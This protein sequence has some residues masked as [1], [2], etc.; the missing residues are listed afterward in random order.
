MGRSRST[1]SPLGRL[2]VGVSLVAL[3][4]LMAVLSAFVVFDRDAGGLLVVLVALGTFTA[5]LVALVVW[6]QVGWVEGG[7]ALATV[8]LL[9]GLYNLPLRSDLVDSP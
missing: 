2:G 5:V 7:W 1:R 9:V 4:W 3:L 8:A 6:R